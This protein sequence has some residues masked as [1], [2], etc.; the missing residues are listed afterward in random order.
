MDAYY[1]DLQLCVNS[2]V[3]D[4][5][6]FLFYI[7]ISAR[8]LHYLI[9]VYNNRYCIDEQTIIMKL[10][11]RQSEILDLIKDH[12]Q[13]YG[14]PPTRAEIA[15]AFGFKSPNAAEEHLKALAKKGVIEMMPGASRGIRLI[16]ADTLGLPIIGKVAAGSPLLSESHIHDHCTIP[17]NFFNPNADYLLQVDGLSMK[18]IGILDGDLI[19]VHSTNQAANN[20]IIVARVD[21][22]VTVKRFQQND[23]IVTLHSENDDFAPIVVDLLSQSFSIEGLYVGVIRR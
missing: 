6:F 15:Q 13:Q 22:E 2:F 23:N 21:D 17:P 19:A 3:N 16:G 8:S 12:L 5:I 18:D 10:T 4:I 20:Q 11:K 7:S 1:R 14:V 9:T